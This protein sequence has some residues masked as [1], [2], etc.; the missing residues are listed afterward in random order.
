MKSYEEVI[1]FLFNQFPSYQSKGI[2]AYKPDLNNI[3]KLCDIINSPQ[4]KIKTIQ[5]YKS[6]GE[7]E[8]KKNG[9]SNVLGCD[10]F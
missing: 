10:G 6:N 5:K 4:K 2:I 7:R 8:S 3:N 1:D 9:D